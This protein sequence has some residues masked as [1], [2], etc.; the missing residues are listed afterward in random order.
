MS[1]REAL[2]ERQIS[3]I[4]THMNRRTEHLGKRLREERPRPSELRAIEMS[5]D[6]LEAYVSVVGDEDDAHQRHLWTI[7]KLREFLQRMASYQEG[8]VRTRD[9]AE[10]P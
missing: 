3:V 8:G 6:E 10:H 9:L 5:L 2:L 4:K 1:E 7:K